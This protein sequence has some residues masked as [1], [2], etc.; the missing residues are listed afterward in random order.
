MVLSRVQIRNFQ[1]LREVDVELGSFVVCVG[2]SSS[3]KSAF[4]R[5]LRLLT[6]NSSGTSYVTQGH[7]TCSVEVA[8]DGHSVKIERGAGANRYTV[9][10]TVYDKCGTSAPGQVDLVLRVSA[11]SYASQFDKP[12]LLDT[13]GSAVA[14]E[15]GELTNVS[16]IFDAVREGNRRKTEAGGKVKTRESDLVALRAEAA[17]FKD[18]PDRICA[19]VDAESALQVAEDIESKRARL[20]D[21]VANLA[22]ADAVVDRLS[23]ELPSVPDLDPLLTAQARRDGFVELLQ[24]V[25]RGRETERLATERSVEAERL[26]EQLHSELHELLEEVGICPTC[27]QSTKNLESV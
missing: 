6:F 3:G 4:V 23:A 2:A 15:L 16:T 17:K 14:K 11:L 10:G 5:A 19:T 26:E 27:Q 12:Y 9:D 18:L 22:V 8:V 25:A 1:S 13:S 20:S 21:V 24:A 7:K